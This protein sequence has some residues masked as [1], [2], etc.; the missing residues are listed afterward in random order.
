M[1]IAHRRNSGVEFS[2]R[3]DL[4]RRTGK[5]WY[6]AQIDIFREPIV[7]VL[8]CLGII[9]I[10]PCVVVQHLFRISCSR[11]IVLHGSLIEKLFE[12]GELKQKRNGRR[13]TDEMKG[14]DLAGDLCISLKLTGRPALS[15]FDYTGIVT[16]QKDVT[17]LCDTR[18]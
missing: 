18:H 8:Q 4:R 12:V 3:L 11:S 9:Q 5:N 13:V 10:V 17:N 6:S 2:G 14:I 15:E 1:Q 7:A 16:S